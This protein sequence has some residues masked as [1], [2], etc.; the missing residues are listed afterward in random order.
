MTELQSSTDKRGPLRSADD[1]IVRRAR[2]GISCVVRNGVVRGPARTMCKHASP[3]EAAGCFSA[4]G[5][6]SGLVAHTPFNYLAGNVRGSMAV[7]RLFRA[8][9]ATTPMNGGRGAKTSGACHLETDEHPY[10]FSQEIK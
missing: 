9:I 5:R 4:P 7:S 10:T 1:P 8:E 6:A 3:Y 2:V